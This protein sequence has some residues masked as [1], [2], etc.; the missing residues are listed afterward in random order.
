MLGPIERERCARHPK[1]WT[2]YRWTWDVDGDITG[3]EPEIVRGC[4]DCAAEED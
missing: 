2:S 1:R 3:G 4:A